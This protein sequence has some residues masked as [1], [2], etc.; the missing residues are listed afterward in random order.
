MAVHTTEIISKD[1][2]IHTAISYESYDL[3]V[4]IRQILILKMLMENDRRQ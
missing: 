2:N 3:C 1:H 4:K